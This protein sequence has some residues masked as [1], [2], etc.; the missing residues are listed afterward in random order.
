MD[1]RVV[2]YRQ[3]FLIFF[4]VIRILEKTAHS[5]DWLVI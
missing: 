5:S 3:L 4:F 2:E 1:Y